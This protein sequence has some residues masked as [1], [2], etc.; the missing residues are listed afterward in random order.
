MFYLFLNS[1]TRKLKSWKLEH[2]KTQKLKNSKCRKLENSKTRKLGSSKTRKLENSKVQ[3]LKTQ[4]LENSKT[5][6]PRTLRLSKKPR[7]PNLEPF[8]TEA[9]SS[10][11][12]VMRNP[13]A[14][15]HRFCNWCK[16]G[17]EENFFHVS[18]TLCTSKYMF[19]DSV[20]YWRTLSIIFA[21]DDNIRVLNIRIEW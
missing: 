5:R 2:S 18:G 7:R 1:K 4:K 11:L 6:K 14:I 15:N 19:F 16:P 13:C 17:N 8:D 9:R 21:R 3:K 10:F 12:N 20:P